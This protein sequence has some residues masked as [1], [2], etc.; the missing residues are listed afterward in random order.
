VI[1]TY[2]FR[3]KDATSGKHLIVAKR[4]QTGRYLQVFVIF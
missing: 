4:V 3:I 1:L 2:R